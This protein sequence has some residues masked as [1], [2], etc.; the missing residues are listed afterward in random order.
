M[1][2]KNKVMYAVECDCCRANYEY[3]RERETVLEECLKFVGW[4]I[5]ERSSSNLHICRY[6]IETY[7]KVL[8]LV[9]LGI[10]QEFEETKS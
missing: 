8:S 10:V 5:V 2:L 1:L 4:A 7:K 3:V 6:C 9:S